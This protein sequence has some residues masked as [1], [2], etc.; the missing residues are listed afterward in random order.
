MSYD[1][2]SIC[3]FFCMFVLGL[4][5]GYGSLTPKTVEGK[6]IT[7]AYAMIGVPLVLICLSNLGRVLADSVRH[8][9]ARFFKIHHQKCATNDGDEP[10]GYHGD[11]YQSADEKNEV[12]FVI[13]VCKAYLQH[14][15][16]EIEKFVLFFVFFSCINIRWV[17]IFHVESH[18]C[19][20][21]CG[22]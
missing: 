16:T 22:M 4:L 11:T 8:T 6:I 5:S 1:T 17:L 2:F 7:M 18:V 15:R 3:I 13:R 20:S 10:N 21:A 19:V 12:K 9:Y 14:H